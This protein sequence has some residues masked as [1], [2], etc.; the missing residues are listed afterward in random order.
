MFYILTFIYKKN[1]NTKKRQKVAV[2]KKRHTS[3]EIHF[4]QLLYFLF[5]DISKK[6]ISKES[7]VNF[8]F[9]HKTTLC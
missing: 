5:L 6:D 7:M 2:Y 1:N 3:F 8:I 9:I 4:N